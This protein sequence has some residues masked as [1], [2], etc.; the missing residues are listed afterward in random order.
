MS[1]EEILISKSYNF[2]KKSNWKFI[3]TSNNFRVE[4]NE[5]YYFQIL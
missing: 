4:L 2:I 5:N 1:L 3:I